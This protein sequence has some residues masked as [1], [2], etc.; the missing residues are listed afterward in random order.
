MSLIGFK[1]K[2]IDFFGG[3]NTGATII[4]IVIDKYSGEKVVKTGH[5]SCA[6]TAIIPVDIYIIRQDD[7]SIFHTP[8]SNVV[9]MIDVWQPK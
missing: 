6:V 2:A 3:N 1:V 4:G 8:C 9:E 5:G 7:M